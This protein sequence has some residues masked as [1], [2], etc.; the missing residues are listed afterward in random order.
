MGTGN[1]GKD[2]EVTLCRDLGVGDNV[3]WVHCPS[4]GW[5]FTKMRKRPAWDLWGHILSRAGHLEAMPGV[6]ENIEVI[7]LDP[8]SR[9]GEPSRHRDTGPRAEGLKAFYLGTS[10]S[11]LQGR[12]G[13]QGVQR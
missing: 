10:A 3:H 5:N 4:N 12:S 6:T 2:L 11:Y 1:V 13:V 8:K 7:Q 9:I